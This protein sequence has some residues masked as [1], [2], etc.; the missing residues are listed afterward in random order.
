MLSELGYLPE[1]PHEF[2]VL[3]HRIILL[4]QQAVDA[5]IPLNGEQ[6]PHGLA[7]GGH[8]GY[9]GMGLD[10]L[11]TATIVAKGRLVQAESFD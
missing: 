9:T 11:Q 4:D 10:A 8:A 3:L 6:D 2:L 1:T 5:L 7:N